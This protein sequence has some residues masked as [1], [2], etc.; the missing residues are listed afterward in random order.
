MEGK[1]RVMTGDLVKPAEKRDI[2]IDLERASDLIECAIYAAKHINV[3]GTDSIAAALWEA[4]DKIADVM[5][6]LGIVEPDGRGN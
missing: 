3:T 1:G 5:E 4:C 6:K 2:E